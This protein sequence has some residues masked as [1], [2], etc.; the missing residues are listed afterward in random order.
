MVL[1]AFSQ[2]FL[3]IFRSTPVCSQECSSGEDGWIFPH[4]TFN[5]SFWKVYTMMLGEVGDVNRYQHKLIAQV[6]YLAFVFLVVILLSNVLIA[7]V[8]ESH[9]FIKNERAEMVFWSNR[10]DFVAEMDTIVVIK[11]NIFK[12][13]RL[14]SSS[15]YSR[16]N[17]SEPTATAATATATAATATGGDHET[18][19]KSSSP[20]TPFRHMWK[21]MIDFLQDDAFLT[22]AVLTEV[23]LYGVLKVIVVVIVIPLWIV[24]GIATAGWFFPPQVREWLFVMKDDNNT[25]L[26]S[27]LNVDHEIDMLSR[28]VAKGRS[29]MKAELAAVRQDCRL[30]RNEMEDIT[31]TVKGELKAVRDLTD[32]LLQLYDSRKQQRPHIPENM[33]MG[34]N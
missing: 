28:E 2:M 15:E 29:E 34:Q 27:N 4:C 17:A 24:L 21:N 6:L 25:V 31:S 9:T 8:T 14:S 30:L 11:R 10:L 7:M 33:M 18:S 19:A 23:I 12:F 5:N 26:K 32:A 20:R 1:I 3:I 16:T 13:L 22:E